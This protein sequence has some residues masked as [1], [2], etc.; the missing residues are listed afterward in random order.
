MPLHTMRSTTF[1]KKIAGKMHSPPMLSCLPPMMADFTPHCQQA[2]Y[3]TILWKSAA[4][5]SPPVLNPLHHGWQ[6]KSSVLLPI[7]ISQGQA[8]APD[9]VLH[10][11]SC[12]CKK[13]C[14]TTQCSH[15]KLSPSCTEFCHCMGET[16]FG[17]SRKV[18]V[19]NDSE[20]NDIGDV[21]AAE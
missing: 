11:I 10:I 2:H 5:L 14:R 13:G 9:E 6:L 20:N 12:N 21:Y 8:T 19:E 7:Y 17:N 1:M 4:L 18:V 3:Q 15:T 16:L